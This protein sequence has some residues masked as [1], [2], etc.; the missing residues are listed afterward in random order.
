MTIML[1]NFLG[2]S[3]TSFGEE[4]ESGGSNLE[5]VDGT[6]ERLYKPICFKRPYKLVR[7]KATG[8]GKNRFNYSFTQMVT[9]A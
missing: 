9:A 6:E 3:S 1:G 7:R 2:I 5:F 4:C 8:P